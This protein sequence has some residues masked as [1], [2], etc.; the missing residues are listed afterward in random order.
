MQDHGTA[1]SDGQLANFL[2]AGAKALVLIAND[3]GP[4]LAD[5]WSRNSEAMQKTL[6]AALRPTVEKRDFPVYLEAEVG[7]KP[8]DQ[9]LAE[10]KSAGYFMSDW[11]KDI[12]SKDAWKPGLKETVKFTRVHV[13]EL[14]FTDPKRLPTTTQLWARIREFGH[15]LCEPGDGPAIRLALKDQPRGDW[16][17]CAMEQIA[18]SGGDPSVFGV[19]CGGDGG[20]WLTVAWT[21]PD[22]EWDLGDGLVFR[23]RK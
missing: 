12:I 6:L 19:E 4:E 14:G 11:A 18:G 5:G 20:R 9:L 8:K 17:W 23:L 7:G 3:L 22:G 13:R 16:F 1:L 15:S 21:R 2:S 10:L